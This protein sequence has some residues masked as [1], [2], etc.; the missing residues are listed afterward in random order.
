MGKNQRVGVG[1]VHLGCR[2]NI[3]WGGERKNPICELVVRS[4]EVVIGPRFQS[5]GGSQATGEGKGSYKQ[6]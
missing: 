3:W 2:G 1:T 6:P 5:R 4:K